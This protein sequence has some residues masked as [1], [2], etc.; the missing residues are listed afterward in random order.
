MYFYVSESLTSP[1]EH[2]RIE[3]IKSL[4]SEL[5]IAGEF[6]VASP[7]RTVEEHMEL[8]FHKGFTTIVGIGSDALASKVAATLFRYDPERAAMGMIPL[9]PAQQLWSL[10]GVKTTRQ[11][12][13]LLSQ[14]RLMTIDMLELGRH[15]AIITSAT[16]RLNTP[17]RFELSFGQAALS[18]QFTDLVIEPSGQVTLADNTLTTLPLW[19]RLWR[20]PTA[21][22]LATTRFTANRWR[23]T[24]EKSCDVVIANQIVAQTP[25]DAKRRPRVLNLIVDRAKIKT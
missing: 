6:A 18:G 3:E 2:R 9:Q 21:D 14:R 19:S 7:A 22:P 11:A 16:I 25:L 1:N 13:E 8:A 24:T 15:R 10:I 17:V 12:I 4:L 20:W 23:F 5:G